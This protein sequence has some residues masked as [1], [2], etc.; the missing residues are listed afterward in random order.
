[1]GSTFYQVQNQED[2]VRIRVPPPFKNKG[3]NVMTV[4]ELKSILSNCPDDMKV[5]I[6]EPLGNSLY[7]YSFVMG[8]RTEDGDNL[9]LFGA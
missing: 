2:S 4:A 1:M 5:L 8:V 9:I 7:Q 6:E 3:A